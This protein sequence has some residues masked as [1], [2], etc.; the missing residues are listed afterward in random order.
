MKDLEHVSS[1][2]K[3]LRN[4]T[5]SKKILVIGGG[6]NQNGSISSSLEILESGLLKGNNFTEIG[7]AGH[8]EGSPDINQETINDFLNKKYD[9]SE[10]KKFKSRISNTIFF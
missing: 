8:P 10:K 4:R 1:F 2:L 7:V 6:G 9:L 5:D 3:K